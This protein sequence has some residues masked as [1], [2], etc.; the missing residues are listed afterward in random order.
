VIGVVDLLHARG[1]LCMGCLKY[2]GTD[3]WPEVV[4]AAARGA[5][6]VVD[7]RCASCGWLGLIFT[8]RAA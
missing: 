2:S 3:A 5:V 7:G 4:R 8:A 6:V 1:P